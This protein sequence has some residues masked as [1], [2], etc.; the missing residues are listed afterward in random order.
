M[1]RMRFVLHARARRVT[2]ATANRLEYFKQAR[3][4][5]RRFHAWFQSCCREGEREEGGWKLALIG[6]AT[7]FK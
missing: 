6:R 3:C 2:R 4:R 7:E 5:R 1:A